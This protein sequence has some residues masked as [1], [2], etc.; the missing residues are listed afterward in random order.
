VWP[1]IPAKAG[2][3]GSLQNSVNVLSVGREEAEGS[4]KTQHLR[5]NCLTELQRRRSGQ[6]GR[7]GTATT[8]DHEMVVRGRA[9][10]KKKRLDADAATS[11]VCKDY[12]LRIRSTDRRGVEW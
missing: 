5:R 10:R 12:Q 8:M 6:S 4:Q 7:K 2:Q 3:I 11:R 9:T 1:A